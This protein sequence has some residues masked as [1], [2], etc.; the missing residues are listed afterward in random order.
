[1]RS[2]VD[3]RSLTFLAALTLADLS[4][5]SDS[6]AE[7]TDLSLLPGPAQTAFLVLPFPTNVHMEALFQGRV[8]R[9]DSGCIRL[10][11]PSDATVVWPFGFE[12]EARGTGEWVVMGNGE[13]LGAIGGRFRFG[14]GELPS[15]HEG[16]GF[17]DELAGQIQVRCPGR[18]WIVG[19]VAPVD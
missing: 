18:F 4:G 16:L 12:L 8:V 5:C 6:P 10:E 13:D 14:G 15:L 11:S 17:S 3:V 2:A 7:P 19:A 1:M 9:D